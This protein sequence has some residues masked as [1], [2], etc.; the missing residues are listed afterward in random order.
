ME[1]IS[2]ILGKQFQ[3]SST[4]TKLFQK[5]KIVFVLTEIAIGGA[6]RVVL[7]I[8]TELQKKDM[9]LLFVL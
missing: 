2:K 7:N 5:M 6:E 9:K 3:K 1:A 8:C 4:F